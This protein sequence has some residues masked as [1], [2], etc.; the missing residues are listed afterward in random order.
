LRSLNSSLESKLPYKLELSAPNLNLLFTISALTETSLISMKAAFPPAPTPIHGIPTLAS[1][2]DLIMHMCCCL[3]TQKTPASATMNMLFPAALPD[4]YLYFTNKT[5]PSSYFPF[6]KEV[7]DVPDFSACTSNNQ[8]KSLKATHAK[9][10]KT[11]A[12]IITMNAALSDVFLMNLPKAICETYKP[13]CMKQP[14]TVFLHIF[15]WF[16]T[17]YGLAT[18][19]DRKENWQRMATT[20]HPSEGFEPLATLLFIGASY[21]S[22]VCYPI[23]DRDVINI[24]LCIIKHCG[25][26]AKEYKNWILRKNAVPPII[27]TINSFKEY[28]ADA[29]AIV[30]QTAMPASQHGYGMTA[31]DDDALVAAYNDLLANFGTAFAAMQETIKNQADSL[32]A[33]Q[34]QLANIRLCMNVGQQP[35]SSGYIP[36]QQ[37]RTFTNHN[38]CSSG[39]QGN[40]R[41]FPQQPTMNYGS[42]GGGQ[43]HNMCPPPNPYKRW[44]IWN[45]CSSYGG[46]VDD[47]HTSATCGKPGPIHNPNATHANIMGGSVA[48]MHKTILPLASGC[49]P[50][51]CCKQQQQRTQQHPPNAYYPPGGTDWQQPTPPAQYG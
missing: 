25:I 51:N 30:N 34:N 23:D 7:D 33:M 47:N 3:Q 43:Q 13:I 42:T 48:K 10:Q 39:G 8:C 20:W 50:P 12:D 21:A 22:A 41:G 26:Y 2:I 4:L 36:A 29:I 14:N 15:D 24:G 31:M 46:D 16:I 9:D 38:K 44:E 17:K 11:Q 32:I 19:K 49:T 35:P 6:P 27:K 40:G 5:Y 37:Q 1:L 28:W 45:H 18:T